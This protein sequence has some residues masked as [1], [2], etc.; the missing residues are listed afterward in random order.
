MKMNTKQL[1]LRK[2]DY[3]SY[4]EEL[5]M[6]KNTIWV[7]KYVINNFEKYCM[8]NDISTINKDVVK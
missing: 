3:F 5:G 1:F 2:G 6:C 8:T 7:N 4:L